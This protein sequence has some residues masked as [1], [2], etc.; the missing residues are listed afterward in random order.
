MLRSGSERRG[1]GVHGETMETPARER[2]HS[3]ST[4][5]RRPRRKRILSRRIGSLH[6]HRHATHHS[7]T[8]SAPA[9]A[10]APAS[11][12][13]AAPATPAF[14]GPL[15]IKYCAACS[16]PPEYC[17]FGPCW[18]K[19]KVLLEKSHPELLAQALAKMSV[20]APAAAPAA[21]P[22]GA[23]A[24]AAA[25]PAADSSAASSAAPAPAAAG[26][27]KKL[28]FKKSDSESDDDEDDDE[29]DEEDGDEDAPGSKPAAAAAASADDDF[30]SA[31]APIKPPKKAAAPAA[32]GI[33]MSLTSRSRKKFVTA[34]RGWESF[35][36]VLKDVSKLLAKKFAC[37]AS[38]VKTSDGSG[39]EIAIQ[40]DLL[41]D[42]P[43]WIAE[44]F[45][46][47]DKKLIWT[48]DK[49]GKKV[50]AF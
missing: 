34:V 18:D 15:R 7:H 38:V 32:P 48:V 4:N 25:A 17:E 14:R 39:S 10:P 27:K 12:A 9:A 36:L 49:A 50:R 31:A 23:A 8:M 5:G 13:A 46:Q 41:Q 16:M 11:A 43:P 37:A 45:K 29:D 6:P 42:L 20:S 44:E 40:G 1:E 26:G 33:Y 22:E 24:P 2:H 21:A 47:I 35:G 28:T 19:C 3:D 30:L